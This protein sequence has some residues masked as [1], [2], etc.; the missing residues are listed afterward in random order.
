MRLGLEEVFLHCG[1]RCSCEG[2]LE[3]TLLYSRTFFFVNALAGQ[4]YAKA[5][6]L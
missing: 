3:S 4:L 5:K 2:E 1:R 6:I